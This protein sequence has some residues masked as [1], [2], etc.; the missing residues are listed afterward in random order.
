VGKMFRN[1]LKGQVSIES[2]I[3]LAT[4]LTILLL[5]LY[6]LQDVFRASVSLSRTQLSR[7]AVQHAILT[8]SSLAMNGL[9]TLSQVDY[10]SYQVRITY[11]SDEVIIVYSNGETERI[12]IHIEPIE[13]DQI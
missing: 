1:R 8:G 13:G 3:A 9:G 7:M 6:S 10:P 12:P 4:Y 5:L 11:F 2:M